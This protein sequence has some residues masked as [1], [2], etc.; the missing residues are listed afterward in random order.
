MK[1]STL[2]TLIASL[3]T[4]AIANTAIAK[5]GH[6][7]QM[8]EERKMIKIEMA[9]EN[10]G[11]VNI[12]INIDGEHN[13]FEFTQEELD[14]PDAIE[15]KLAGVDEK[16]RESVM[17][18]LNNLSAGTGHIVFHHD[19][20]GDGQHMLKK[21]FVVIDGSHGHDSEVIIDLAKNGDFTQLHKIVGSHTM[22]G[23]SSDSDG[24]PV[25][26]KFKRGDGVSLLGD[27]KHSVSV[28]EKLIN[29]TNLTPEQLDAIA[30]MVENKR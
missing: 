11:P 8:H 27:S 24:N 9:H 20:E 10:E 25:V 19:G 22:S 29:N 26:F 17:S 16:T 3:F 12:E 18:A 7:D 4:V 14:D 15:A 5:A 23:S 1:K 2:T 30:Q 21:K 13:A 28:I 6:D